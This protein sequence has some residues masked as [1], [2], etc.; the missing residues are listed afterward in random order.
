MSLENFI[1]SMLNIDIKIIQEISTRSNADNSM[2]ISIKLKPLNTTLCPLCNT[3]P[4]THGYYSRILNHATLI[5]RK[6]TLIYKRR[7]FRCTNCEYT[8]H[9]KNPFINSN[10][11]LT[12]ETKINVLKDLKSIHT[13]Y[14][15]CAIR[16][17]LSVTK[18]Q[19][20]FDNHVAIDRKPL[21]A[22]LSIDEHYFPNSDYES[23]YCC[24]LMDFSSG[25][26]IDILP[27]RKKDYISSYFTA[28]KNATLDPITHLSELNNVQFVSIDLYDT[29]RIIAQ[30]FFPNALVCADSFHV[31]KNLT[32]AF[33]DVRLK[34]RRTTEDENLQYLLTK[35]KFI[36]NHNINL[37]NEAKF[38]K[39]YNRYLNFRDIMNILF[40]AFPSLQVAYSLKEDYIFF[41]ETCLAKEVKDQLATLIVKFSSCN[42]PEYIPFYNLLINWNTEIINSFS[43]VNYKRINNSFI[44]SMNRK[45][46]T[47]M[48]NANGFTNFKRTRNRFLYCLN[49]NDSYKI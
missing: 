15:S 37:D 5:N 18:V 1:T 12:F 43:H 19:R 25:L 23:L 7:R 42:I 21:P 13:T 30:H 47:L 9:E 20:L 46:E 10:E 36:F 14:T 35:F 34:C 8:F 28:I 49:K 29:Y 16:H 22:V 39:R 2:I 38:N 41:N 44:E 11:N 3:K 17:N 31:I 48:Y 32:D 27:D 40:E 4:L 33:K 6:C 45:I 24:I 26:I